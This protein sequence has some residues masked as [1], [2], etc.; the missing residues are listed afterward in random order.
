MKKIKSIF[1]CF[2]ALLMLSSCALKKSD[3]TV[4]DSKSESNADSNIELSEDKST[5][6]VDGV[7]YRNNFQGDL[8]LRNP[9]Y[10]TEPL[11][12]DGT[13]QY[14]RLEGVEYDLIYNA[15][16]EKKGVSENIYCRDDQWKKLND[17]YSNS[18]NFVYRCVVRS[19]G[20]AAKT[21][22]LDD[23]NVK[24]LNELV[25][26]CENN[27]YI[28]SSVSD[29]SN[30]KSVENDSLDG[31]SYR[32][33]LS[34]NDGLFSMVARE[35]FVIDGALVYKYHEVMIEDKTLIVDVPEELSDYFVSAIYS[36]NLNE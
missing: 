33:G 35:F 18:S 34:S 12:D 19:N 14:Y 2:I 3:S 20:E 13:D 29:S 32:F 31:K 4:S 28:P 10:G 9:K 17:Y 8:I 6:T 30:I 23:I 22:E 24:K 11:L 27:A 5:I 7:V 25:D 21:I 15:G 36:L 16:S 26:F 1:V